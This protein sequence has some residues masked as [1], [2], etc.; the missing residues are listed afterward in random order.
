[1]KYSSLC[2]DTG[3]IIVF[4]PVFVLT[5]FVEGIRYID[6]QNLRNGVLEMCVTASDVLCA[7]AFPGGLLEPGMGG[8]ES[9]LLLPR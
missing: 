5:V 6:L 1:M 7:T 3:Y 8:F 4:V 2:K 9:A